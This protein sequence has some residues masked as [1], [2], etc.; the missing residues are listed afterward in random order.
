MSTK[1]VA[2]TIE[3]LK[4]ISELDEFKNNKYNI[5][6]GQDEN[7]AYK[8]I[9]LSQI[10]GMLIGGTTGSGK[11]VF[12][13]SVI[14]SLLFKCSPDE[15]RF[16]FLGNKVPDQFLY[17]LL[18]HNLSGEILDEKES[19]SALNWTIGE[20]ERRYKLFIDLTNAGKR[21]KNIKEYNLTLS[22]S[23]KLPQIVLFIDELFELTM[24]DQA[25]TKK[26]L[27]QLIA[28]GRKAGI[29]TIVAGQ[30]PRISADLKKLFPVKIA[31]K[32]NTVDDSV[33]LLGEA[34]AEKLER[35]GQM[36]VQDCVTE[37][38]EKLQGVYINHENLVAV[39]EFII[40]NNEELIGYKKIKCIKDK[41]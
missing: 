24:F 32:M 33:L 22:E 37:K 16:I 27:C 19:I 39:I 26:A 11:S 15:F 2:P 7:G 13:S 38:I 30:A 10:S 1:Y 12:I 40:K 14:T 21:V 8:I 35:Q 25:A 28:K 36:L 29:C 18:P 3:F 20:M 5:P 6:L 23:E 4:D 41:S 9:D 31:F 34:G 17:C